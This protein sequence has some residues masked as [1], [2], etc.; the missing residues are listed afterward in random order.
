MEGEAPMI[1]LNYVFCIFMMLD[2]DV[3]FGVL[4]RKFILTVI[5]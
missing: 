5:E 1:F 4:R 2:V 3:C